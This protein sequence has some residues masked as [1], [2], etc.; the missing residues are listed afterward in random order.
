MTTKTYARIAV[1]LSAAGALFAGYLGLTRMTS[2]I[3]AFGESCPFFLGRPACYTG[4]LIFAAS[5]GISVVGLAIR[6]ESKWP[7]LANALVTSAGALFAGKLAIDELGT[8]AMYRLGLPTCAYGFVFF[9][10]LFVLSLAAMASRPRPRDSGNRCAPGDAAAE[11][12]FSSARGAPPA[13]SPRFH[14]A[15]STN[16][17]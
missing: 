7:V 2:G 9:V 8:H 3:C 12:S 6:T 5:F 11:S 1:P 17:P 14:S 13:R 4:F 16:R 15:R 10:A